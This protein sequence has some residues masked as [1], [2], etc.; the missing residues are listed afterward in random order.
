L[1]H[2]I[3]APSV[4][5]AAAAPDPD[6]LT[7][8]QAMADTE[9]ISKWRAAAE[10]EIQ[11]LK[12]MGTWIEVPQTEATSKIL[13]GTWAYRCK[14]SPDGE[15]KKYKA[16]YCIRGDLQEGVFNTYIPL[17]SWSTVRVLLA[18]TL[19][20][21]WTTC[22]IDFASAFVQ[23]K[24]KDPVWIH[25]PHGFRSLKGPNTCLR[26]VKS[27]YGLSVRPVCGLNTSQTAFMPLD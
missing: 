11:T 1:S 2:Y 24:L 18:F 27:L 17:I 13:P 19:T 8:D 14:R 10:M 7:H 3:A 5:A 9:H 23:A 26:L 20:F 25:L 16:R 12:R 22:S 6:T 15:I 4:Y 21:G